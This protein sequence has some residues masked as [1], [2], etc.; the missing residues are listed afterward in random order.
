MLCFTGKVS[1]GEAFCI[2][3]L[4]DCSL[5]PIIND[6]MALKAFLRIDVPGRNGRPRYTRGINR[7]I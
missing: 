3:I 4:I 2:I 7:I 1:G 6:K 5:H